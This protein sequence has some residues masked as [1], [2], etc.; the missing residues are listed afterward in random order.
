MNISNIDKKIVDN[1][2]GLIRSNRL[3]HAILLIG[4]NED[5]RRNLAQYISSAF[6][7]TGDIKPCGHCVNCKKAKNT[8]HPDIIISDPIKDD[9][10]SIFKISVVRELRQDAYIIPNEA[11]C[12]VYVLHSA[13]KMNTQAQNAL[14]KIIEEPPAYAE[15]ILTCESASP[16]LDTIISR[17]TSFDLGAE[18]FSG[19]DE[20]D[21][22][23][24]NLA[25]EISR[26]LVQPT[27]LDLLRITAKF[28]NN[29]ELMSD[30][31]K[32]L[33]V[34]FRDAMTIKAGSNKTLGTNIEESRMLASKLSL[35][36]LLKLI[37]DIDELSS[38]IN[39]NSNKSLLCTRFSSLLRATVF[40]R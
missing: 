40:N 3:P 17:V 2:D 34:V 30:V 9:N 15:F 21:E 11:N 27:E 7:C 23:A 25:Y 6:V 33:N 4:G 35:N 12:K 18:E 22:E 20:K 14:L 13:D 37:E 16:L 5:D 28:E 10:E 26:A 19:N 1:I 38:S 8:S 32:P 31:L 36:S 39:R 29:K 24:I